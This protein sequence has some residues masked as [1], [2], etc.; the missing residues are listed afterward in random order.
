MLTEVPWRDTVIDKPL[1]IQ[2][3]HF[4]LYQPPG[5]GFDLIEE[6]MESHLGVTVHRTASIYR[7]EGEFMEW[8]NDWAKTMA[9]D[10]DSAYVLERAVLPSM[11]GRGHGAIVSTVST[12]SLTP[13]H[14]SAASVTGK[15]A[16]VEFTRS[17]ALGFAQDGA[18]CSCILPSAI[19]MSIRTSSPEEVIDSHLFLLSE[20]TLFIT[21]ISPGEQ[22]VSCGGTCFQNIGI[23]TSGE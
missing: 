14:N 13:H 5:L 3:G 20:I 12:Q 6:E 17:I 9:V 2:N 8:K 10:L 15:Q 16:I 23:G 21:G 1:P 11:R 18:G 7:D 22:M 4:V 19:I